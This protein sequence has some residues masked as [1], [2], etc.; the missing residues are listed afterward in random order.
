MVANQGLPPIFSRLVEPYLN[1]IAHIPVDDNT[2]D[3]PDINR[4]LT[5]MINFGGLG[6]LTGVAFR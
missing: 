6:L 5:Q 1:D 2:A 3:F 4:L